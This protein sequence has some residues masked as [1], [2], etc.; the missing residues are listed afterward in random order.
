MVQ[1]SDCVY[2][3][4][5]YSTLTKIL[6]RF[7]AIINRT[8]WR[9]ELRHAS[10]YWPTSSRDAPCAKLISSVGKCLYVNVL[11]ESER[12]NDSEYLVRNLL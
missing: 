2:L 1:Y 8:K 7:K 9:R 5:R 3:S 6:F 4:Y 10:F 12:L 11:T